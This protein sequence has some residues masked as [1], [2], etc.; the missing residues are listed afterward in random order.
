MLYVTYAHNTQVQQAPKLHLISLV[1]TWQPLG[2]TTIR[3]PATAGTL[4]TKSAL[5]QRFGLLHKFSLLGKW[6][7]RTSD[8]HNKSIRRITTVVYGS[9]Q[10]LHK[11]TPCS[12]S[13][14]HSQPPQMSVSL[15]RA[16]RTFYH[17]DWTFTASQTRNKDTTRSGR[18]R[19][20]TGCPWTI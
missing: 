8:E 12:P 14:R 13:D 18:T 4:D 2:P 1:R 11:E 16:I 5:Y 3:P 17:K 19:S 15:L 6:W 9:N 10:N 7:M 20:R